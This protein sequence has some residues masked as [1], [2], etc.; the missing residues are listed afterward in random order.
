MK[1]KII[2]AALCDAREIT[3][4]SLAGFDNISVNGA[5]LLTSPRAKEIMNRY[6]VRLNTAMVLEIP[7]GQ[8]VSVKIVNGKAAIGPGDDGT[9]VFLIVNGRLTVEDGSREAVQSY[10]RILVNGKLL[11]PAGYRGRFPDLTVNGKTEYYPDGAALLKGDTEVDDL[12]AARAAGTLYYCPGSLFFLDPAMDIE[13]LLEKDLRF[14]AR[15]IVIA[16]SLLGKLVPR[17]DEES[18]IVRVPDGTVRVDGGLDLKMNTIR[19]YGPRLYVSGDVS[20]LDG[21]ALSSLEYLYA[22]G[23]ASVSKDLEDAFEGIQSVCKRVKIIDPEQGILSDRPSVRIGAAM[24]E[25]YPKGVRVE[26]CARVTISEDLSP[27]DILEKLRISDCAVV[28]C[29]KE[30]EDAV[31][32]IA[33]DTAMVRIYGQD[34]E[35]SADSETPGNPKDTVLINAAEYKM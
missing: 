33:E 15:K 28:V 5:I 31:H 21:E 9:N 11:M 18:E 22:E 19:R 4:E 25:K 16:E 32:M 13:K 29:T 24:L 2:N 35:E 23:E 14:S 34:G 1:N 3:E 17:F 8:E 26:D 27:E 12:F 30:Q 6:P 7:D 10:Y 20:I